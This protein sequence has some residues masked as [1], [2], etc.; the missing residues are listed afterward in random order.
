MADLLY[1][2]RGSLRPASGAVVGGGEAALPFG[3][4]GVRPYVWRL[5]PT[6]FADD[7]GGGHG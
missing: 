7:G 6:P 5:R 1:L 2:K 3:A 4:G